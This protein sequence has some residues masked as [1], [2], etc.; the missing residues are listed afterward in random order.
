MN[1]GH[2]SLGYQS[3]NLTKV[4]EAASRTK[5]DKT[6]QTTLVN[7]DNEQEICWEDW[8]VYRTH[9]SKCCTAVLG[10]KWDWLL[11]VFG[12]CSIWYC[13]I[14]WFQIVIVSS[15]SA[16]SSLRIKIKETCV[17]CKKSFKCIC[18]NIAINGAFFPVICVEEII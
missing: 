6:M 5:Q 18:N 2:C 3:S 1:R 11:R 8:A 10:S 14:G 16:L 17:E 4:K 7:V 15:R 9:Q 12:W 13:T